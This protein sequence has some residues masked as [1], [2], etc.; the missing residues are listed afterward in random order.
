MV[1]GQGLATDTAEIALAPGSYAYHQDT[2]K[3]FV[4]TST[5]ASLIQA[6]GQKTPVYYQHRDRVFTECALPQSV[7]AMPIAEEGDYLVLENPAE[8]G[9]HPK[10]DNSDQDC[11]TL[12]MGSKVNIPGPCQF[13][14]WPGQNATLVPGHRLRSNQYLECRVFNEE[15]ATQNWK[16]ATIRKAESVVNAEDGEEGDG[17]EA[18]AQERTFVAGQRI[19]IRGDE[20]SFFIPPTG[21]EVIPD[22]DG[23][24]VREAVTL[25]RLEYA[26]LID[27]A[28][29]K[30]Y[31]KGPDV[32]FPEPTEIF[33]EVDG[34]RKFSAEELNALQGIHVKV[35]SP[36]MKDGSEVP[37][38]GDADFDVGAELFIVGGMQHRE[39]EDG[40][41]DPIIMPI[42]YPDERLS[43]VRYGSRT[44]HYATAIPPGDGL[45]VMSRQKGDIKT[46]R[47]P[48]M[49]LPDPRSHV[50]IKRVLTA[51]QGSLW[52]PGNPEVEQY[53][54]ALAAQA[55]AA[56]TSNMGYVE[57]E[58]PTSG[59]LVA[60][61]LSA[62]A[63]PMMR[64]MG[65]ATKGALAEPE[66][67]RKRERAGKAAMPDEF[68]RGTTY[69]PPRTITMDT[70]FNVPQICPW[71]GYAVRVVD[72][73]DNR[74]TVVGPASILLNFDEELEVLTLS[75]GKPKNTDRT[76]QTVY[77]RVKNN[78]ISDIVE[79]VYTADHVPL[80]LKL[81]FTVDFEGDDDL[82]FD[83]E[84]PVKLLTDHVRSV[85]KGRIRKLGVKEFWSAGADHIRDFILGE[86]PE[87]GDRP[88][89]LFRQ[90]GMRIKDVEILDITIKNSKVAEML[91]RAEEEVVQNNI[92]LERDAR[93]L[94]TLKKTEEIRREKS[95]ATHETK[96]L[97]TMLTQAVIEMER[98]TDL[99]K[100]EATF[101]TAE[102]KE[103][104]DAAREKI[105]DVEASA[106]L[107]RDKAQHDE[108]I[109]VRQVAHD[110]E[111][112]RI[113]AE[114][115]AAK[116]RFAAL[117]GQ[118]TE[119]LLTLSNQDTMT[120][121]AQAGSVQ[122]MLGGGNLVE[123]LGRIMSGGNGHTPKPFKQVLESLV[124]VGAGAESED[125]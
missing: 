80:D 20:V 114:T 78:K 5:G 38:D 51:K 118:F 92:Q 43:L 48:D 39:T 14:L 37:E 68:S 49:C 60:D 59:S 97:A 16:E 32:V 76:I 125:E 10:R 113:E 110:N 86:V 30:R 52:Y 116:E 42:F 89:M 82:W 33:L 11:P 111:L 47:G 101:E 63:E 72:K 100:H 120:K 107:A 79:N 8:D 91:E 12:K 73:Q 61:Y 112:A 87:E 23:E 35:I 93:E 53:N 117:E 95:E 83:V 96:K 13:A 94:A 17:A 22:E 55:E 54:R 81:S 28:G 65:V 123:V 56:S 29:D 25:E 31:P 18:S 98:E 1:Q 70:K 77:L 104:A 24:Y 74:R 34:R 106:E 85:L 99:R 26:V 57:R 108:D 9:A 84:N 122:N 90:N 105:A 58:E 124:G 45:Y 36:Y 50:V 121:I 19:I 21:I 75:R 62:E 27:E 119:A 15:A 7:F 2:A 6:S 71:T 67:R 4:R 109:R 46:E 3:G 44:K 64:S 115:A 102:A 66:V 103:K 69:T 41:E 40:F 88:G